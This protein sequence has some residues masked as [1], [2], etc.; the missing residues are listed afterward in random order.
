M[1]LRFYPST[2]IMIRRHAVDPKYITHSTWYRSFLFRWR[3]SIDNFVRQGQLCNL[4]LRSWSNPRR[5]KTMGPRL[6]AANQPRNPNS[7]QKRGWHWQRESSQH[8][9]CN[10][11]VHAF[12]KALSVSGIKL[13]W[14][15]RHVYTQQS[16]CESLCIDDLMLIRRRY[17]QAHLR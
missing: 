7:N 13:F 1:V 4:E 11:R 3:K 10:Q 17:T 14:T 16:T 6:R 2:L 9:C 5:S 15:P 8:R 12:I